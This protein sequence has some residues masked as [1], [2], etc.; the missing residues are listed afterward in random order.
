MV[1]RGSVLNLVKIV[2]RQ[3]EVH[4][5]ISQMSRNLR[6]ALGDQDSLPQRPA[7]GTRSG[8]VESGQLESRK[9]LWKLVVSLYSAILKEPWSRF[10][11]SKE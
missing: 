10:F 6:T 5:D 7:D 4:S 8:P 9:G 3:A 11:F 1:L 2:V